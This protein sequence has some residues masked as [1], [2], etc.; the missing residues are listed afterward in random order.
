M[1]WICIGSIVWAFI[2]V[3]LVWALCKA[4]GRGE[5]K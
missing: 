1:K 5:A 3:F 2:A 4:A